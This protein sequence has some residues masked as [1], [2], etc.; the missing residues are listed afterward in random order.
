[1]RVAQKVFEGA[2][3]A[4]SLGPWGMQ[5]AVLARVFFD[6][7]QYLFREGF[8][9]KLCRHAYSLMAGVNILNGYVHK[10]ACHERKEGQTH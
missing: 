6:G 8:G 1:M 5:L 3:F 4:K 2:S 7:E 10:R 9:E